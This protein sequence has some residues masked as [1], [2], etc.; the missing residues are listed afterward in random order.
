MTAVA[1]G[2]SVWDV[3]EADWGS[4]ND[5]FWHNAITLAVARTNGQIYNQT[6]ACEIRDVGGN[7]P[8]ISN[9]IRAAGITDPIFPFRMGVATHSQ[10]PGGRWILRVGRGSQT[11]EIEGDNDPDRL[12]SAAEGYVHLVIHHVEGD[13]TFS[14]PLDEDNLIATGVTDDPYA[15]NN[16]AAGAFLTALASAPGTDTIRFA[17]VRPTVD[18]GRVDL[19]ALTV[20]TDTTPDNVPATGEPSITGSL[21]VGTTLTAGVGTVAD[22]N[23][24]DDA[25]F[26]YRWLRANDPG[27]GLS[28]FNIE[29]ANGPSYTLRESDRGYR[30]GLCV[31]FTDDDGYSQTRYSHTS[32]TVY[33]EATV[34]IL[35][36]DG[37]LPGDTLS[38]SIDDPDSR[39]PVLYQIV[40]QSRRNAQNP[41]PTTLPSQTTTYTLR[42][43]D[44]GR[45]VRASLVWTEGG[46]T[47]YVIGRWRD[48]ELRN[49]P[50]TG[51]PSIDG[52][53]R[54]GVTLTATVDDVEDLNGTDS[55]TFSPV[56]KWQTRA[57]GGSWT[58][59]AGAFGTTYTLADD[60]G[61]VEDQIRVEYS[62]TDDD[63]YSEVVRS[64]AVD[65]MQSI[66]VQK[67]RASSEF[68][69]AAAATVQSVVFLVDFDFGALGHVRLWNGYGDLEWDG[70][71][72]SGA[73]HLLGVSDI[74]ET[75]TI[76]ASGMKVTLSGLPTDSLTRAL[77]GE[78]Q[79]APVTFRVGFMAD[80]NTVVTEPVTLFRGRV[81]S[82]TV[83]TSG[84]TSTIS[85]DVENDL[86]VLERPSN[87]RYTPEDHRREFGDD[88]FL[89][90]VPT[91]QNADLELRRE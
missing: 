43:T 15:A 39:L 69:A 80:D 45:Q 7:G 46:V 89:D 54:P 66:D 87:R 38:L 76:S 72:W 27:T 5:V 53:G 12:S 47:S 23:G 77:T 86:A 78:Y 16:T 34:S 88:A 70:L 1:D 74:D 21:S 29:L 2:T 64:L 50:A 13:R 33:R 22:E 10:Y 91:L 56:Y 42:F 44:G 40:W 4:E 24:T 63:G 59:I 18:S 73:G 9:D 19:D 60:L 37:L 17:I 6:A 35:P 58:D 26:T 30:I 65:V 51:R 82:M 20:G 41:A 49:S 32:E 31:F 71:T 79:N 25:V 75:A 61:N 83:A 90:F 8:R 57:S 14:V 85:V 52:L 3:A 81:D 84:D 36:S 68:T 55:F 28:N 62:F 48:V 67:L 11:D